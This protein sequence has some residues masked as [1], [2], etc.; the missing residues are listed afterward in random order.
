MTRSPIAV[1]QLNVARGKNDNGSLGFAQN[2][3][4]SRVHKNL[5]PD[6]CP[7]DLWLALR[8]SRGLTGEV[9]KA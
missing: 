2:L 8:A 3:A 4:Q 1:A 9:Q 6:A 5:E 7:L